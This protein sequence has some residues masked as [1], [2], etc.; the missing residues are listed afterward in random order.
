[1]GGEISL[2]FSPQAKCTDRAADTDRRSYCGQRNESLRPLI[3]A[4]LEAKIIPPSCLKGIKETIFL[5]APTVYV[6]IL[7]DL[8]EM[9]RTCSCITG[10]GGG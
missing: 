4:F 7:M 3:S 8:R 9:I 10:G 2:D 5:K 1:L 6:K